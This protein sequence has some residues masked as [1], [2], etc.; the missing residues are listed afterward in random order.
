MQSM[1][2]S[3]P[4]TNSGIVT[5]VTRAHSVPT[6]FHLCFLSVGPLFSVVAC[7]L[8]HS[9]R[10]SHLNYIIYGQS[11]H[12]YN[13]EG[14]LATSD[15]CASATSSICVA[16]TAIIEDESATGA[17]ERSKPAIRCL[18]EGLGGTTKSTSVTCRVSKAMYK[19]WTTRLT[20]QQ[21]CPI[22]AQHTHRS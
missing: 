22:P 20:G 16:P 21:T 12:E 13:N 9:A 6:L 5:G 15:N 8:F 10:I 3:P 4:F 2:T 17:A 11:S 1:H 14:Q 18:Q 19:T 7:L